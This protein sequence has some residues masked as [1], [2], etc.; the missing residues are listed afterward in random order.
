LSTGCSIGA[1]QTYFDGNDVRDPGPVENDAP[2]YEAWPMLI[3]HVP[4]D[5]CTWPPIHGGN[6]WHYQKPS[7]GE[8]VAVLDEVYHLNE[9]YRSPRPWAKWTAYG[10]SKDRDGTPFPGGGIIVG[11]PGEQPMQAIPPGFGGCTIYG[12]LT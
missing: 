1:I 4:E 8:T 7:T 10:V 12:E 11:K 6:I 5:V 2:T 9:A 3:S